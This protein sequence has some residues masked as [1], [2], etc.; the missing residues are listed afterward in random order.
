LNLSKGTTG[1]LCAFARHEVDHYCTGCGSY[2]LDLGQRAE[3]RQTH[4]GRQ[5]DGIQHHGWPHLAGLFPNI[6]SSGRDDPRLRPNRIVQHVFAEIALLLVG[7]GRGVAALN[8]AVLAAGDIF[9][10]A[11]LHVVGAAERVIIAERD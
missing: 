5:T 3:W 6:R 10:R 8:V 7:A 9:G 4:R 1:G 2:S 11:D